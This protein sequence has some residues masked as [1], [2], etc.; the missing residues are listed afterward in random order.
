MNFIF[1]RRGVVRAFQNLVSQALFLSL[2]IANSFI[3]RVAQAD[4]S[5][6]LIELS[7][8]LR[9]ADD[10]NWHSLL[11]YRANSL[12]GGVESEIDDSAF[13]NAPDGKNN[14]QH[15]LTATIEGFFAL[16]EQGHEDSHP[17][18]KFPA[19]LDWLAEK[20]EIDP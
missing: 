3:V 4:Y 18:C 17:Q 13:F 6:E 2:L 12:I 1:K 20:L 16:P 7:S 5:D 14:P 19:R 10:S 11:H 8:K 9:L 15:E